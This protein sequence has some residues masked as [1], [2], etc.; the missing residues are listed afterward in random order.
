VTG[1]VPFF[2][3]GPPQNFT[4]TANSGEALALERSQ[5]ANN[6]SNPWI[7]LEWMR[8]L[9]AATDPRAPYN[10]WDNYQD[11]Y[12]DPQDDNNLIGDCVFTWGRARLMDDDGNELII[13]IPNVGAL[14]P[15]LAGYGIT[16]TVSGNTLSIS[17]RSRWTRIYALD[18]NLFTNSNSALSGGIRYWDI[19]V[20]SPSFDV[21]YPPVYCRQTKPDDINQW[22]ASA[23]STATPPNIF[24][25]IGALRRKVLVEAGWMASETEFPEIPEAFAASVVTLTPLGLMMRV[26]TTTPVY[27]V[28]VQVDGTHEYE[29]GLVGV[30]PRYW[31]GLHPRRIA[32]GVSPDVVPED[33]YWAADIQWLLASPGISD[34]VTFFSFRDLFPSVNAYSGVGGYPAIWT[35]YI[36]AG[37]PWGYSRTV[38][39]WE[40][41]RTFEITA[42]E[43]TFS[44]GADFWVNKWGGPGGV[45]AS[46]RIPGRPDLTEQFER[47]SPDDITAGYRSTG[48]DDIWFDSNLPMRAGTTYQNEGAAWGFD[49]VTHIH[50]EPQDRASVH[51][52]DM[53]PPYQLHQK[54]PKTAWLWDL[55]EFHVRAWRRSYRQ[56]KGERDIPVAP[57]R[58]LLSGLDAAGAGEEFGEYVIYLTFTGY[59]DLISNG[60]AC[61]SDGVASTSPYFVTI[62]NL[63]S[64]IARRGFSYLLD[65]IQFPAAYPAG[66]VIPKRLY[67][68]GETTEYLG[69]YSVVYNWYRYAQHRFV[70]LRFPGE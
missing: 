21:A 23:W 1:D 14:V 44:N 5:S 52:F 68:P 9:H 54:I 10:A 47:V 62:D 65:S 29:G 7:L 2:A 11:F 67:G 28:A 66:V 55:L 4:E 70:D 45:D 3:A 6:I 27:D 60:V 35:A 8:E 69:L 12:A 41:R 36:P 50:P 15:T 31:A 39:D 56:V 13:T 18:C 43:D 34:G 42:E 59:S 16:G 51:P 38:Y 57:R 53:V 19:S 22:T 37:G 48:P 26:P 25:T 46:V 33:N 24:N 61:R 49:G 20:A 32:H 63:A 64:F 58:S 40:I 30:S 17:N